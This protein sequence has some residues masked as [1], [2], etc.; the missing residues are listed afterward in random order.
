MKQFFQDQEIEIQINAQEKMVVVLL[1]TQRYEFP[2]RQEGN[3]TYLYKDHQ[4]LEVH[5]IFRQAS[6][7]II[8]VGTQQHTIQWK[9]PYDL[10]LAQSA[11]GAGQGKVCAVMPGRVAQILVKAGD[12]VTQGQALM[13]L[14]AMKMENEVKAPCDGYVENVSVSKDMS[15]EAGQT[16]LQ[17]TS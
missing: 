6:K 7:K 12:V 5:E 10:S 2:Y 3:Q 8:R 16:L 13:I 14:E 17:I 4:W 1:G 11:S 9:D 15:V